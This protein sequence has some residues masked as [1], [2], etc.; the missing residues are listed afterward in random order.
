MTAKLTKISLNEQNLKRY[1]SQRNVIKQTG[2]SK[3]NYGEIKIMCDADFDGHDIACLLIQFFSKW[4]DLFL[5]KRIKR[6]NTP[7]YVARKKGQPTKYYYKVSDYE[8]EKSKLSSWNVEYMKGLGSLI[9]E[10]YKFAINDPQDTVITYNQDSRK[11]L[12]MAFGSD[13]QLRKD[14]LLNAV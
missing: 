11:S 10:D 12:D 14:W 2:E 9:E 4:P 13:S 5:Q 3:L 7:I 1:N 6:L 8:K